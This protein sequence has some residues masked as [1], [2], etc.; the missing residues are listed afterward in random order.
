MKD[1]LPRIRYANPTLDIEVTKA[2]KTKDDAWRPE[3][4]LTFGA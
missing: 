1:H 4:E 3:L 2:P